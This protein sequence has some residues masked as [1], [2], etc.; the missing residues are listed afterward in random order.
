M[1]F[2]GT[3][4]VGDTA[5]QQSQV[6]SS[7]PNILAE[8]FLGPLLLEVRPFISFSPLSHY[9]EFYWLRESGLLKTLWEKEKT[10]MKLNTGQVKFYRYM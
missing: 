10:Q 6:S 1:I 9:L 7:K 8:D 5:V 4:S 2:S 3:T